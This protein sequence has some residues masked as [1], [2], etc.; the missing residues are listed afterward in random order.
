MCEPP[1]VVKRAFKD[2]TRGDE[3]MSAAQLAEFMRTFQNDTGVTEADARKAMVEFISFSVENSTSR[4]LRVLGFGPSPGSSKRGLLREPT[5]E[6]ETPP[7]F[8]LKAFLKFL[9]S[10]IFNSHRADSSDK[11][12]KL[13][14][15]SPFYS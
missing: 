5:P 14:H 11:V 10:T 4:S 1:E 8:T 6:T 13:T 15:W 7:T 2:V 3:V 9:L 12:P